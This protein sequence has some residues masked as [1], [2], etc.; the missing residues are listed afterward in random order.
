MAAIPTQK[1]PFWKVI[2]KMEYDPL[3]A[4]QWWNECEPMQRGLVIEA[5]PVNLLHLMLG[6]LPLDQD[7]IHGANDGF[8][9]SPIE[10]MGYARRTLHCAIMYSSNQNVCRKAN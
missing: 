4:V 7:I 5:E 8:T 10:W 3:Y 2:V 6:D 9:T 1:N